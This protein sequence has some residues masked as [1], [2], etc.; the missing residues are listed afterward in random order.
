MGELSSLRKQPK[1]QKQRSE[2]QNSL[3]EN[4]VPRFSLLP[5]STERRVGETTLGTRLA[6]GKARK[7]SEATGRAAKIT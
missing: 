7:T 3:Q 1:E 5:V 2:P 4:L 6:S